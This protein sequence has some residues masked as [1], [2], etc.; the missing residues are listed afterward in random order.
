MFVIDSADIRRMEL[1]KMELHSLL[2][3][4]KLAG[5]SLLIFAN[6]QD[7]SG[8]LSIES[9]AKVLD[10]HSLGENGRHWKIVGCSAWTG[11][12]LIEGIQWIV[13]DIAGRIYMME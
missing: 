5:A 13:K 8:A 6:K 7:L 12:G 10:L 2:K 9:I 1:C 3:Q 4:E 11:K